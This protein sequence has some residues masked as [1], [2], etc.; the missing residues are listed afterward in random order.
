MLK[1]KKISAVIH[2]MAPQL[3]HYLDAYEHLLISLARQKSAYV[4]CIV[5]V[6]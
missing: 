5:P 4:F 1:H 3:G 6:E 2:E